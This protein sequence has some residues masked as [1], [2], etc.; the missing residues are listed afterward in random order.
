MQGI[1]CVMPDVFESIYSIPIFN[2]CDDDGNTDDDIDADICDIA[3][4]GIALW[5]LS[6]NIINY[7]P[8]AA[9]LKR[10]CSYFETQLLHISM[11]KF[12]LSKHILNH[13]NNFLIESESELI[14]STEHKLLCCL[15][16]IKRCVETWEP[17][18]TVETI[19][20]LSNSVKNFDSMWLEIQKFYLQN[21]CGIFITAA[22]AES[23]PC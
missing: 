14:N 20:K 6:L 4:S 18:K 7:Q 21:A 15:F 5:N 12:F 16:E 17:V 8:D 10:L 23:W 1:Y 2:V 13:L 11:N 19:Y 9:D 22:T 3:V